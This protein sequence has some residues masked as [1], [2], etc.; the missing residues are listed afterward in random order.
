[1][2]ETEF[3]EIKGKIV[4]GVFALTTRTFILQII[5]FTATFILTI[6][7]DPAVFG[8]FAVVSAVIS[9]LSYFS[10]IGL[11][12]ALIQQKEEPSQVE[13]ACVFTLQQ[14]LVG[15]IVI[16]GLLFS[17]SFGRFYGLDS[18][19]VFL[20]QLLLLSFL[21]SSLRTIP[22]ILLER[23]L[24]FSRLILPQILETASFYL[25]AIILA[26]MGVGIRS[27]AWAALTRGL[28]GLIAIYIVSPWKIKI[29]ISLKPIKKLISYGI[30][31]QLNSMLALVK[32]DLM[33]IF[34]GKILPFSQI[35]YLSWAKKWAEAPLRLIMDSV[36]K[37]TF[38]AYARLQGNKEMLGKA[39]KKSFFF[40]ALL[41]FPAT[42][43]LIACINPMVHLIPKY[44][45]WEPALVPF[46]LF[47]F[48]SVFASFSS[49]LVNALNAVGKIKKTL[50]LMIMWTVL[51]WILTP[52][53]SLLMGFTGVS[54]AAF[55]ISFTGIIP[56]MMMKRYVSFP[57]FASVI[58]PAVATVCM[59][60]PLVIFLRI[61]QDLTV[62]VGSVVL[63][64]FIY[65]LIVRFWMDQEI[66]PYL[67]KFLQ[68]K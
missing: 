58:K 32:D 26:L 16:I 38:P 62:V 31:F 8:I 36:I 18:D 19:G 9:F 65:G 17:A 56:V 42:V 35:G 67:P 53:L 48:S 3:T 4:G 66:K 40:L 44:G 21:L 29:K 59:I 51:T 11:A 46:Y 6:I 61:S 2:Q 23:K 39:I 60:V 28:V 13:L 57:V 41:V 55:F 49:P 24:E 37:V 5:S 30:P 50:V 54:V 10:D 15:T 34:L 33:I 1:M 7:L 52:T 47:T 27:F 20:L 12:A 64:L 14:L 25:V 22:S 43:I 63:S 45:K 68:R